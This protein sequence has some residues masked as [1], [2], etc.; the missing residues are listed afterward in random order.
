V[1]QGGVDAGGGGVQAQGANDGDADLF[2]AANQRRSSKRY[3]ISLSC[4]MAVASVVLPM[5]PVPFSSIATG[6]W[7][8][9]AAAMRACGSVRP[10]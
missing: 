5:P 3:S 7:V 8:S 1:C 4:R 9:R 2:S 6:F 10:W